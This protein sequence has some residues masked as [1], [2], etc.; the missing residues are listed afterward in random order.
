MITYCIHTAMILVVSM[1]PVLL[2]AATDSPVVARKS[3]VGIQSIVKPSHA[4]LF[5]RD[6][7]IVIGRVVHTEI[8]RLAE[9]GEHM[10][11]SIHYQSI[12][13]LPE[14]WGIV[15]KL[16]VDETIK[17]EPAAVIEDCILAYGQSK[18]DLEQY[19]QLPP[20]ELFRTSE[21]RDHVP[22]AAY[23]L[24]PISTEMQSRFAPVPPAAMD[25]GTT[26]PTRMYE[27]IIRPNAVEADRVEQTADQLKIRVERYRAANEIDTLI[28]NVN[29]LNNERYA[30]L[31]ELLMSRRDGLGQPMMAE[32]D[33]RHIEQLTAMSRDSTEAAAAWHN[34]WS[35]FRS[36]YVTLP[37]KEPTAGD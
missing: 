11:V 2:I 1:S 14:T 15:A 31:L 36:K 10:S 16:K 25:V 19:L 24:T 27:L 9:E 12:V 7:R 30:H 4:R 8:K 18:Q 6:S 21:H 17:G 20:Q 37:L 35:T 32:E 23:Y 13:P 5:G 33:L 3:Q 34:W 28:D 26:K 29:G 22:V